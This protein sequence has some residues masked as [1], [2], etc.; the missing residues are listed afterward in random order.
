MTDSV[1][2][3]IP[4]VPENTIDPAAG[5]NEAIKIIDRLLQLKVL[6]MKQNTP[7]AS[8]V[9]GNRYI[10]GASPTGAWAG[11]PLEVAEWVE[12]GFWEF[13]K[14]S[15]TVY[16]TSIYLNTGSDWVPASAGGGAA[17]GGITGSIADQEDLQDEFDLRE[18]ILTAGSN[19]TIDRT[20]PEAPVIS[21][22]GGSGGSAEWGDI[23]GDIEDQADLIDLLDEKEFVLVA[24]TNITINRSNPKAPVI[25]ASGGGGGGGQVDSVVAGEGITVDNTD[26]ENPEVS[27][28]FSV[29]EYKMTAGT[30]IAIDRTDPEAP[31]ISATGGGGGMDNPMTTEGDM[32]VG[33]E[34]GE[35]E[36]LAAGGD[37]QVLT[38]DSGV[39]KWKYPEYIDI[40]YLVVGGGG[41]GGPSV[42]T[43]G[44]VGSGGGGGGQVKT[45]T[46]V[47]RTGDSET[48]VIG[49][50]GTVANTGVPGNGNNGGDSKFGQITSVGGGGGAG[51]GTS[52][53]LAAKSG[54]NGGGGSSYNTTGAAGETGGYSGGNGLSGVGSGGGGGAGANGSNA[55]TGQAGAGGAGLLSS[56][57][58]TPTYYGGG[59]GAGGSSGG[60]SAGAGGNGGGGAG[61]S[62]ATTWNGVNGT[63]NTGGGGGGAGGLAAGAKSAG[64]GGSGVVIARY[65]GIQRA[66]GGTVTQ[67]SGY[68]IH[69]FT[70]SGTFE[71]M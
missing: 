64:N 3:G 5:L 23:G 18:F 19:I 53:N 55:V 15:A 40:E 6:A 58:G 70:S 52:G 32:I 42:T 63:A 2:N 13:S 21:A 33:G 22:T 37:G 57:S 26:P 25:S 41:S 44:N 48:V 47:L 36:R 39:P 61:G 67:S 31:V 17:W 1:N 68:T 34:D 60:A 35:P 30:G 16:G 62:S 10:V 51:S 46:I 12:G 54:G 43:A 38:I 4:F 29:A 11:H 45:G 66:T 7:A 69:T 8:P 50:G 24:G 20:D 56:I 71:V 65:R 59:G 14:A 28:D 9:V 49:A 27:V